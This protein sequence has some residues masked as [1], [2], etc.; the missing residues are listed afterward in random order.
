M[1]KD[2]IIR[3]SAEEFITFKVQEKDKGIQVRYENET[4]WMT[5]KAMAELFNVEQPAIAKHLI[6]IYNEKE[7]D[8]DS[9]YSKMELVQKEGNRRVKRQV[10][11]YNLDAIISVGYRVNSLRATQFRRWATNI[12]KTFTIQGYV[13]DKE[14]MKNGSFI[15]KDYFEKLLEEIRKI[16]LSE[17]RFYQK[18]TDIYSSCSVDYDKDSEITK[19]YFKTVQNKLHYAITGIYHLME[20]PIKILKNKG[21]E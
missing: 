6:N 5:Q 21:K 15:D 10:E 8:K 16:R 2:L 13:L 3:S 4:L 19:E 1:A 7:L 14:R 12:L 11:F 20:N 9:T 17:R 18:I